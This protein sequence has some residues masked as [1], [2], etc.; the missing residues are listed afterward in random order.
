MQQG[1]GRCWHA[2]TPALQGP[3]NVHKHFARHVTASFAAVH[4]LATICSPCLRTLRSEGRCR[5]GRNHQ[6]GHPACRN[7]PQWK[8]VREV[9]RAV[10]SAAE[11]LGMRRHGRIM[12][13]HSGR[14]LPLTSEEAQEQAPVQA[15]SA[16]KQACR[17]RQ[18]AELMPL[19]GAGRQR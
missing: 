12:G 6:R 1:G 16:L 7:D 15:L 2:C 10:R 11:P 14:W 4:K 3:L 17:R 13:H 8:V 19:N 5:E 18:G 9:Q